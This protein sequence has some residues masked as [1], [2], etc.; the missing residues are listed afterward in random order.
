VRRIKNL[1][2][3][4]KVSGPKT[5]LKRVKL[6]LL[7]GCNGGSSGVAEGAKVGNKKKRQE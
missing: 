6:G 5:K 4:K 3:Q 7:G 1:G 2:N